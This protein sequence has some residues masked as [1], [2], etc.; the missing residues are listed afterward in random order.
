MIP[1]FSYH[2]C[3]CASLCICHHLYLSSYLLFCRLIF[4][5]LSFFAGFHCWF[6][7]LFYSLLFIFTIF[8]FYYFL[9]ASSASY[10]SCSLLPSLLLSSTSF[11]EACWKL[12]GQNP[13][14]ETKNKK[15][16]NTKMMM[17]NLVSMLARQTRM[18]QKVARKIDYD[19]K[20]PTPPIKKE[21]QILETRED[22]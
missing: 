22:Y 12:G 10:S 21:T 20:F 3:F 1:L 5:S 18:H 11:R 9:H 4:L 2:L 17:S 13:I 14:R 6:L 15:Q 8:F 7:G 19:Q 16:E